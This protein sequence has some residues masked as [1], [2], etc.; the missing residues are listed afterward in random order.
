MYKF[1]KRSQERLDTCHPKLKELFSEVIK[2]KDCSI[3]CGYRDKDEQD[4]LFKSG[5]S[6]AKWPNSY[7][8]KIPS[9]AVDVLPYPFNV[10]DWTDTRKLYMF[11]GFV[12]AIAA[13]LN[14]KIRSGADWDGDFEV[15]D[16]NFHDLPHFE[17]IEE[18][19][20]DNT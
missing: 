20:S 3:L 18:S 14:I 15:K 10:E 1:S 17:L 12:R 7:H 13:K 9:L 8:N 11:V 16:Q 6:K 4:E 19:E 2:Y 5:K